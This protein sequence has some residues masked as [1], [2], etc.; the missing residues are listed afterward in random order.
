MLLPG[1]TFDWSKFKSTQCWRQHKRD[2]D[3][4]NFWSSRSFE[5]GHPRRI[6]KVVLGPILIDPD[7]VAWVGVTVI[8]WTIAYACLVDLQ[9]LLV[10]ASLKGDGP[11]NYK[12][13][14][15]SG[16]RQRAASNKQQA[17]CVKVYSLKKII[18][19]YNR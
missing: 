6:S 18:K 10:T 17:T 4:V 7:P 13:Q 2:L 11:T 16:E 1:S 14:A 19:V 8:C 12:H 15:S 5:P 3:L 9:A